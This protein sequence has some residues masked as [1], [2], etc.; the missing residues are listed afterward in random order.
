MRCILVFVL[1]ASGLAFSPL[2]RGGGLERNRGVP[3]YGVPSFAQLLRRPL[4]LAEAVNIAAAQNAVILAAQKEVEARYGIAIQVRS[5]VL[6]HVTES[7]SYLYRQ[8]SLLEVTELPTFRLF[9]PQL[10][11]DRTIGG[12]HTSFPNNQF[13]ENDVRVVQSVYEGG[14]LLSALR[15]E[16]LIR[17]QALVDFQTTLADV[18][19]QVHIAYDDAQLAALEIKLREQEVGLLGGIYD[20]ITEQ[21]KI[22]VVT[23][24]EELRAKVEQDNARTPL[25]IARQDLVI[26]KQHLL[27]LMGYDVPD[28]SANDV[29]LDLSTPLRALQYDQDLPAALVTAERQR[30]ELASIYLAGKL[31]DEA[32]VVAKAGNK[33]SIQGFAAYDAASRVQSRD[34]SDPVHGA[35]VGAQL[36]WPL[37][38]G[39]LTQGRI[40]EAVAR[41]GQVAHNTD[42]LS[43]Q[44]KFQVRTA[45]ARLV[46]T[47][48]ILNIQA[49]NIDSAVRA[50]DLSETRFFTGIGTEVEVLSAQTALTDARD[51]YA[52]ALRNYSVAYSQLLR[53]TGEDLR[54]K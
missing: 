49:G 28:I 7:A 26:A 38:D 39:F 33:P 30:S 10:G 2:A 43:R 27:Q 19:L 42:E 40:K 45:W 25:A 53:A 5:I 6:P 32:I 22:G 15:Q 37:F 47:R 1:I 31:A 44:I 46:E 21:R 29:A 20:K 51:F 24:F 48:N 14:R 54:W 8:D 11:I 13:W 3:V 35:L 41:R 50:I 23:E 52:T 9:I 34:P 17:E 12:G 16:K 4:S 36:S 18:L